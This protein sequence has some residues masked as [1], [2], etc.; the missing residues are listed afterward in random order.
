MCSTSPPNVLWPT[1][2]EGQ[3]VCSV[4]FLDVMADIWSLKSWLEPYSHAR[5]P[6]SSW[7]RHD[8]K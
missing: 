4:G 3:R 7:C 6:P 8:G 2:N 1:R 5:I